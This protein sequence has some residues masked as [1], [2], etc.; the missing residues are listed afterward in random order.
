[1][2]NRRP[3]SV[4]IHVGQ[5]I[6]AHRLAAGLAQTDLAQKLGISF[7][8]LQKYEKGMNRVGAGRLSRIAHVLNIPVTKFFEN[9]A[10][11]PASA[12]AFPF[13]FVSD[14]H[15]LRLM[16]AY[17]EIDNR[18][19]RHILADLVE[20]MATTRPRARVASRKA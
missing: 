5:T 4:D 15:A 6:R 8:Q 13:R 17:S 1:M 16:R 9:E 14:R 2:S 7:Q 3:D 10:E 20:V 19:I 12:N 11:L 18:D